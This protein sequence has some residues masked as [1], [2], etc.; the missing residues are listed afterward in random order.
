[1]SSSLNVNVGN[2]NL[3]S[4]IILASGTCNFGRELAE[5]Y[6]LSILGGISS[7]GLTIKPRAGN[8]GIR[9][10]ECDSGMLNSVSFLNVEL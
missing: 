4:P 10:A 6:D 1:M 2:V 3:K 8:P 7:K 9:V 5:Y